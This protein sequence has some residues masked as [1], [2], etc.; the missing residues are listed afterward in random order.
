MDLVLKDLIAEI[1]LN[2]RTVWDIYIKFYTAFILFNLTGLGFVAEKVK[3]QH[4]KRV[5]MWAFISQNVLTALTSSAIAYYSW[6]AFVRTA[7]LEARRAAL[8][9]LVL[10][11]VIIGSTLPGPLTTL[12]ALAN[13]VAQ[14]FFIA[15]WIVVC[16]ARVL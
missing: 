1:G 15:S 7:N 12:G 14:V 11:P 2:V 13:T 8:A 6:E 5:L 4:A 3:S 16:R 10:D 9:G